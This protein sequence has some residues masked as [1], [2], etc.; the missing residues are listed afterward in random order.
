M[1]SKTK[2]KASPPPKPEVV[3]TREL[4]NGPVVLTRADVSRLTLFQNPCDLRRDLHLFIEYVRERSIKRSVRGND[5]PKADT[6]RLAK[7]LSDP[8]AVAEV[9]EN[10]RARWI[11]FIDSLAQRLGL[12]EYDT[13]GIYAGYSSQEKSYP[14]NYMT[15]RESAY[16]RY[17]ALSLANQE[18]RLLEL[19]ASDYRPDEYSPN[20]NEFFSLGVLARLDGFTPWGSGTGVMSTLEFAPVRRFLLELLAHCELD[21]WLSTADLVAHLKAEYPYFLI[22]TGP[23]VDKWNR[24]TGRYENFHECVGN[25]YTRGEPVSEAAADAFERVEGRYVERFLEGL[26]LLMGYV[27][28]AYGANATPDI[29]PARDVLQAFRV[30]SRLARAL[31][32]EFAEPTITVQPNFEIFV[33]SEIYPAHVL[34][35]LLPLADLVSSDVVTILKLRREKVANALIQDEHLDVI[36]LLERLGGR[37]LPQNVIRELRE[38]GEHSSKFTLYMNYALFEGDA[39]LP[40]AQPFIAEEITPTLRLAHSPATLYARLE[41]AG[42]MPLFIE[43]GKENL[44]S[45]PEGARSVFPRRSAQ[46]V[47]QPIEKPDVEL[48]REAQITLHFPTDEVLE[49]FRKA[50]VD[51]RCSIVADK[52]V[53]TI[54]YMRRYEPQVAA[55]IAA[56]GSEYRLRVIDLE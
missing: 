31:R 1:A 53:R 34:A 26:P 55:V 25:S 18:R 2:T 4:P 5:L 40:A 45:L 44:T 8:D 36:G 16:E 28:V 22:P 9:R 48:K 38:W 47:P 21:T 14:D 11:D 35:A 56:L 42:L 52:G 43:H 7:L 29:F 27:D 3:F 6:T 23:L 39:A 13:S 17:L 19:L 51:A 15:V 32:G 49:R 41:K 20:G 50:L 10:G 33:Q 46:K 24:P 30:K 54:T 37:N 12:V